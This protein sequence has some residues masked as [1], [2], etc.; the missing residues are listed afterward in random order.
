V[1]LVSSQY[2]EILADAR[3]QALYLFGRDDSS[4]SH[5]YG[6]CASKWPPVL[7]KGKPQAGRGSQSRL[8]GT[9]RRHDGKL[10]LTY[11]DHPLYYYVGDS[12]GR[13]LCQGVSEFGG[14]WLVVRANGTAVR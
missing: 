10:Q 1:K 5:C 3:G 12:P 13:V 4:P 11:A 7:V 2:G 8:I 14:P 6:T 9:S